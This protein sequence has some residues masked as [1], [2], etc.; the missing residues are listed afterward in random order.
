MFLKKIMTD[1]AAGHISQ[2]EADTTIANIEAKDRGLEA[3]EEERVTTE[4]Q[5]R[6]IKSKGRLK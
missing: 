4:T 1:L 5:K 6:S 2:E 3:E